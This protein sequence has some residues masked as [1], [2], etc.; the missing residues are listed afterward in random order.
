SGVESIN[1][2][3][4]EPLDDANTPAPSPFDDEVLT[5]NTSAPR[6]DPAHP[7]L[8]PHQLPRLSL[9]AN[10]DLQTM[11]GRHARDEMAAQSSNP[12]AHLVMDVSL[13][14]GARDWSQVDDK[15][16][17]RAA[18]AQYAQVHDIPERY[19]KGWLEQHSEQL[20]LTTGGDGKPVQPSDFIYEGSPAYDFEKRTLRVAASLPIF[21]KLRDD[22]MA[23]LNAVD[24][25]GEWAFGSQES[26]GEKLLDV[27]APVAH[28][29]LKGAEMAARP[30]SAA[31]AAVWSKIRSGNLN[32][33]DIDPLTANALAQALQGGEQPDYAK[34]PLAEGVRHS[35]TL[36]NINPRLPAL[37]GGITEAVTSPSN[38][39]AA[40]VGKPALQALKSSRVG[41]GV[42]AGLS[43]AM[44]GETKLAEFFS[45]GGR[46]LDI[47]TAAVDASKAADAA[48]GLLVTIKDAEGNLH[49]I[50][51]A[52]GEIEENIKTLPRIM[53]MSV[54]EA[55]EKHPKL[56]SHVAER[57]ANAQERAARF[58]A[59]AS[60]ADL[61]DDYRQTHAEEAAR[62]HD[63]AA[64]LRDVQAAIEEHRNPTPVKA[65]QPAASET[66]D[67]TLSEQMDALKGGRRAVVEI[68]SD[69]LADPDVQT[70]V[71]RGFRSFKTFD[72]GRIIY[73]PRQVSR[74]QVVEAMDAGTLGA[75]GVPLA[76]GGTP[77]P[78]VGE[79]SIPRPSLPARV[80]RQFVN[81]YHLPKSVQASADLSATMRQGL[82]PLAAHPSFIKD[83]MRNQV[84]AFASQDA[85]DALKDAIIN[86]PDYGLMKDSGLYLSSVRGSAPE[87][88]F[89][90]AWSEKIPVVKQSDRAYSA[91]LDTVRVKSFEMYAA[92]LK[93]KGITDEK[94]YSDIA[95][96]INRAT[97]RAEGR[98][99]DAIA[100]V[101]NFPLFSPRLTASRFQVLN[102]VFYMRM[103]PAARRIAVRE[104]MR[105]TGTFSATV[106]L[107]TLAGARTSLDPRNANFG[108]IVVGNTHLDIGAGEL[109]AIRYTAQMTD[110]FAREAKGE[111]LD[112]KWTPTAITMR[113][114]RS[115]LGPLPSYAVDV[116]TG[117]D[118]SGN[119]VEWKRRALQMAVPFVVNDLY[120]GW[121]D[122]GAWG[123]V[124]ASPAILGV[125][126]NTYREKQKH[127]RFSS[128]RS[129]SYTN[130]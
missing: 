38:L 75:H 113:F 26:P 93:A 119:P 128:G 92:E 102:P 77:L 19:T 44:G 101:L 8:S 31:D 86:H 63:E 124:K 90:S 127:G 73:D 106:G 9:P 59:E 50:N 118:Y 41:A 48:E 108:K 62:A 100:P 117:K 110:A 35:E 122:S 57:L 87:E 42:A 116:K 52:T 49:R 58:E 34:N 46:V 6:Y 120:E 24:R 79:S 115:K 12:D 88:M 68:T 109:Q 130:S 2:D 39:L 4:V 30:F 66:A 36:K 85:A 74:E 111:R 7:S 18:V 129:H 27:A 53:G 10:P 94:T 55:L 22:Y 103:T 69:Q 54:P 23:S 96:W 32:P 47:E 61:P 15:G 83:M 82:I 11:E 107:A 21:K 81:A 37:L 123:A 20:H 71:P 56:D 89:S 126:V 65:A 98:I 72:G 60:R 121:R 91:A 114:L 1:L 25:A 5:T 3:G 45:R 80:G 17:V 78:A 99:V 64:Y 13:P 70:I 112:K 125:G 28:T 84:K 40:G 51:T 104:M 14:H 16:A 43:E 76:D 67:G 29:A 97:G 95:H 105:A 33:T